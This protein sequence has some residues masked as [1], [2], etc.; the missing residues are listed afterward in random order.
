MRVRTIAVQ[1]SRFILPN[2]LRPMLS[3][4]PGTLAH[5]Q[6][7]VKCGIDYAPGLQSTCR[8]LWRRSACWKLPM[9]EQRRTRILRT[10]D[11][12]HQLARESTVS[13]RQ[14][15]TTIP[16]AQQ[17]QRDQSD[18]ITSCAFQRPMASRVGR[19]TYPDRR[20]YRT[21]LTGAIRRSGIA[22]LETIGGMKEK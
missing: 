8:C 16:V 6:A 19:R 7:R 18:S 5:R 13:V 1:T 22:G 15:R 14:S 3:P 11:S 21:A 20:Y 9:L 2:P 10:R 4:A 12:R 17:S